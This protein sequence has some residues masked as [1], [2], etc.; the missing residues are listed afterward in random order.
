MD[1]LWVNDLRFWLRLVFWIKCGI[2]LGIRH[3]DDPVVSLDV[4][5][6]GRRLD[7][8]LGHDS[9]VRP[10]LTGVTLGVGAVVDVA[11]LIR[12]VLTLTELVEQ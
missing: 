7:N 9:L 1:L 10:K 5:L 3:L 12:H 6:R 11:L 8:R 4:E 2:R